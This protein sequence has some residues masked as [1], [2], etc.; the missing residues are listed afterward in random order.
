MTQD[1]TRAQNTRLLRK[2]LQNPRKLQCVGNSRYNHASNEFRKYCVRRDNQLATYAIITYLKRKGVNENLL[3]SATQQRGARE[4]CR[5]P[6]RCKSR[7]PVDLLT[8]RYVR[9]PYYPIEFAVIVMLNDNTRSFTGQQIHQLIRKSV[10]VRKLSAVLASNSGRKGRKLFRRTGVDDNTNRTTYKL[11]QNVIRNLRGMPV[12]Q[13]L[14]F[15]R[16]L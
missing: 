16:Q 8:R 9:V 7:G 10:P 14:Q 2:I 13:I 1:Q 12:Q 11:K 6:P 4:Y 5:N 3:P 15:I